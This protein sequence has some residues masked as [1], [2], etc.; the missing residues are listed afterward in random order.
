MVNKI[1]LMNKSNIPLFSD[2]MVVHT[3][4]ILVFSV[5]TYN[6]NYIGTTVRQAFVFYFICYQQLTA[7]IHPLYW[8]ET[9]FQS[10]FKAT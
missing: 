8:V 2:R 4:C 6:H 9:S 1:C 5:N 7:V 10:T 3:V